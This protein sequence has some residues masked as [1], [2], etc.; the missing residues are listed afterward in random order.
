MLKIRPH[1][2]LCMKAYRGKGYSEEFNNNMKMIIESI[3][4]ENESIQIVLGIDDICDK[5]PHNVQNIKC[6]SEDKV[7]RMDDKICKYFNIKEDT[8]D[9]NNLIEEVYIKINEEQIDDICSD[10]EWYNVANCKQL[11]LKKTIK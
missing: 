8:Y 9:Y 4:G 1:H 10:C 6:E 3:K 7:N 5:C 2:I 11:I